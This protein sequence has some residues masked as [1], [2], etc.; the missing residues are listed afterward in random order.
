MLLWWFA[1]DEY[2]LT[3]MKWTGA[4]HRVWGQGWTN[5]WVSYKEAVMERPIHNVCAMLHACQWSV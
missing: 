5:K 1:S 2:L 3:H 4:W